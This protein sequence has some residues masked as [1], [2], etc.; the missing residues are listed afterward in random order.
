MFGMFVEHVVADVFLVGQHLLNR[1][2][3][4]S[5]TQIRPDLFVVEGAGNLA[6]MFSLVPVLSARRKTSPR[7]NASAVGTIPS[8]PAGPVS[9]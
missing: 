7:H 2:L 9:G 6:L 4:P 3:C 1:A 8:H 5:P